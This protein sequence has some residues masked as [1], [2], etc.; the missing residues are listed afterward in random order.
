LFGSSSN[1]DEAAAAKIE[2]SAESSLKPNGL[3][4]DCIEVGCGAGINRSDVSDGVRAEDKVEFGSTFNEENNEASKAAEAAS[5]LSAASGCCGAKSDS[6][7]PPNMLLVVAASLKN[8]A[9]ELAKD[10]NADKPGIEADRPGKPDN[11]LDAAGAESKPNEEVGW[12]AELENCKQ[13]TKHKHAWID[14]NNKR[15]QSKPEAEQRRP[16]AIGSDRE[17][18]TA[19]AIHQRREVS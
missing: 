6:A 10:D 16:E 3:S 7:A 13:S 19:L 2:L 5:E 4:V 12:N 11:K 17:N 8:G 14:N 9:C 1:R 18:E 15:N